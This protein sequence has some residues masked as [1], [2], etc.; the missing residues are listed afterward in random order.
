MDRLLINDYLAE[1]DRLRATSGSVTE[2]I[3]SEALKGLLKEWPK[4]QRLVFLAQHPYETGM[5]A[6]VVP[7]GTILHE[8]RVPLG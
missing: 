3:I 2:G 5:K 6:R 7:D 1:I 4:R 8:I